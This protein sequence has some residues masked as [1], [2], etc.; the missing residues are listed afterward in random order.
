MSSLAIQLATP[1]NLA[2]GTGI[3]LG[4]GSY[5]YTYRKTSD[6]EASIQKITQS[7]SKLEGDPKVLLNVQLELRRLAYDIDHM[8]RDV[9]QLRQAITFNEIHVTRLTDYM[10]A[11]DPK[12]N[13]LF[14]ESHGIHEI[15]EELPVYVSAVRSHNYQQPK[16]LPINIDDDVDSIAKMASIPQS[17]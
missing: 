10:R 13:S 6:L 12:F 17:Y 3:I 15:K 8:N 2:S 9:T 5:L 14:G 1:Q 11:N 16:S 4:L 7:I